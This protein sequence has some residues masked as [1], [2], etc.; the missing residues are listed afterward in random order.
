MNTEHSNTRKPVTSSITNDDGQGQEKVVRHRGRQGSR[1]RTSQLQQYHRQVPVKDD[2]EQIYEQEYGTGDDQYGDDEYQIVADTKY[3]PL[4]TN[5]NTENG[6]IMIQSY[7]GGYGD[8]NPLLVMSESS[9]RPRE[10]SSSMKDGKQV[11]QETTTS[12]PISV[13]RMMSMRM[14]K[15]RKMMKMMKNKSSMAMVKSINEASANMR[16][17]NS[18]MNQQSEASASSLSSTSAGSSRMMHVNNMNNVRMNLDSHHSSSS[19][20]QSQSYPHDDE[21]EEIGRAHV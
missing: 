13:A 3:E 14:S 16:R 2:T 4:K 9:A 15:S 10:S 5:T 18:K 17:R 1:H 19:V 8:K 12:R 20:S 21:D 11:E 6:K 7:K